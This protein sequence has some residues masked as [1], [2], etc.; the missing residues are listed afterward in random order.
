MEDESKYF[1]K[2]EPSE[3][4]IFV[5]TFRRFSVLYDAISKDVTTLARFMYKLDEE[6]VKQ[7]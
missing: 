3:M 1:E 6:F 4:K 5:N 2:L 7:M